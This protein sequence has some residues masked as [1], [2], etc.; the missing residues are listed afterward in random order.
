MA[1][2]GREAELRALDERASKIDGELV[3]SQR[4]LEK[5][6][7]IHAPAVGEVVAAQP[8][9]DAEVKALA[10]TLL[11]AASSAGALSDEVKQL[12]LQQSNVRTLLQLIDDV[13]EL[14]SSAEEVQ[15]FMRE[16]EY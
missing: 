11:R 1:N 8:N 4:E 5:L 16:E 6:C 15:Q 14:R 3:Q 7:R 9:L 10:Q 12:D 2:D 13:Q